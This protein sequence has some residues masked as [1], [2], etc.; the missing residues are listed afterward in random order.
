VLEELDARLAAVLKDG[1]AVAAALQMAETYLK[2]ACERP[3]LWNLLFEHHL[4]SG[5]PMPPTYQQ[6]FEA[7]AARVEEA[8]APLYAEH[9]GEQ[10]KRAAR[11]IWAGVHGI[12]SLATA[13]KLSA[14]TQE[15][16][17]PLVE[18][19]VRNYLGGA[20]ASLAVLP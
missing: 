17:G 8:L 19:L 20:K 12:A 5:A 13:D 3:R 11:A 18:D 9:Q 1:D 7:L 14:V 4:P 15:T 6:K 2:F 16:A 10:R